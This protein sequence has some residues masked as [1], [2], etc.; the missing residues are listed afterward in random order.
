M[1]PQ[2]ISLIEAWRKRVE[3]AP[4]D[5]DVWGR[6]ATILDAHGLP[7]EAEVAYRRAFEL[8]PTSFHYPYLLGLNLD[9]Q[10][11][12]VEEKLPFFEAAEETNSAYPPLFLRKGDLL[13]RD[14]RLEDARRAYERALELDPKYAAAHAGL[15]ALLLGLDEVEKALEHILIAKAVAPRD[16]PINASL[17]RAYSMLGRHAEAQKIMDDLKNMSIMLG[18]GDVARQEVRKA[19]ISSEACFERARQNMDVKRWDEAIRELRTVVVAN[20]THA[21]AHDRL[22]QCFFNKGQYLESIPHFE[23]AIAA[24]PAFTSSRLRLAGAQTS[25][26]QFSQA[27]TTLKAII[28]SPEVKRHMEAKI[29]LG[30]LYIRAQRLPDAIA[31]LEAAART[32]PLPGSGELIWGRALAMASRQ[33]EALAHLQEYVLANPKDANG[34]YTLGLVFEELGHKNDAIRVYTTA[35]SLNPNHGG[36]ARLEELRRR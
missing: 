32:G 26:G 27:E 11:R 25:A 30:D 4:E 12:S 16:R 8:E 28:A 24:D 13:S 21:G 3:A 15:G 1:E 35:V 10:G 5:H 18:D 7:L 22:G 23:R 19:G 17:A 9:I 14:G 29:A 33:T 2:V 34:F 31:T 36:A 20:P 6:Y